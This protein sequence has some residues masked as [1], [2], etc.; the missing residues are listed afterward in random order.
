MLLDFDRF[1]RRVID[2]DLRARRD[3]VEPVDR[4]VVLAHVVVALGAAGVV[5]ERDAG[6]DHVDEGRAAVRDRAP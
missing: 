4:I 5:V 2:R 6:A 1:A 3:E